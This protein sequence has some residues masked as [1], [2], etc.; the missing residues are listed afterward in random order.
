MPIFPANPDWMEHY[1]PVWGRLIVKLPNAR[2]LDGFNGLIQ[3]GQFFW[4]SPGG[5]VYDMHQ[6]PHTHLMIKP[7]MLAVTGL[8]TYRSAASPRARINRAGYQIHT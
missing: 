6:W 2:N 5:V 8:H 7:G 1:N 3:P 4:R